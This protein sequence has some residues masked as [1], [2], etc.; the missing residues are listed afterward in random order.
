[1]L[2]PGGQPGGGGGWAKVELTDALF[3]VKQIGCSTTHAWIQVRYGLAAT[4]FVLYDSEIIWFTLIPTE[5][6]CHVC[7]SNKI[8]DENHFLLDCK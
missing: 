4:R 7:T 8:E 2:M 5:R 3:W 1:M 6:I